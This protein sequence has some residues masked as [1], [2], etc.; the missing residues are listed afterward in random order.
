[1]NTEHRDI[2]RITEKDY[3]GYIIGIIVL[4]LTGAIIFEISQESPQ[5]ITP[6]EERPQETPTPEAVQQPPAIQQAAINQ[7]A[8]NQ[9]IQQRNREIEKANE[10]A[11]YQARMQNWENEVNKEKAVTFPK[12]NTVYNEAHN[13][14]SIA[15]E[16]ARRDYQF[17][18]SWKSQNAHP[19][20]KLIIMQE[21]CS[22]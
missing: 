9:Y 15:C 3:S 18:Q 1:M 4:A 5:K 19:F 6:I 8:M 20:E 11:T 12:N 10:A 16:N 22:Q 7:E 17:E 2:S 14:D 13:Y 21:R